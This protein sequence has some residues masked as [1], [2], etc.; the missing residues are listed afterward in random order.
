MLLRLVAP[1]TGSSPR[2]SDK[3]CLKYSW[4]RSSNTN[5]AGNGVLQISWNL[6]DYEGS[7]R[8]A[9]APSSQLHSAVCYLPCRVASVLAAAV[10]ASSCLGLDSGP[11]TREQSLR[12]SLR[13]RL[14][15]RQTDDLT[16][17]ATAPTRN[18][19]PS[20]SRCSLSRHRSSNSGIILPL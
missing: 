6:K 8:N 15:S 18:K 2:N 7:F 16:A 12:L 10:A 14:G 5:M 19:A 17:S 1:A 4:P 13:R 9:A 3:S 20:T 11:G